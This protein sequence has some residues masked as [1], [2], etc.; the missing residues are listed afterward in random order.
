MTFC[1]PPVGTLLVVKLRDPAEVAFAK[2]Q[3]HLFVYTGRSRTGYYLAATSL[4]T[5]TTGI[6]FE[7]D[8]VLTANEENT[9]DPAS[10]A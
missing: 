2:V 3:G 8:E 4:K 10:Q 7:E 5:G 6:F 9:H 1:D